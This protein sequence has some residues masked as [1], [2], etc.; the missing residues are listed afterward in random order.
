M[1]PLAAI[2][3]KS[4]EVEE[5]IVAFFVFERCAP[6]DVLEAIW[7]YVEPVYVL[8]LGP[9]VLMDNLSSAGSSSLESADGGATLVSASSSRRG[10]MIT[11]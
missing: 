9:K 8:S 11:F 7:R 2:T 3:I 10:V 4:I 6:V 1:C 5:Y